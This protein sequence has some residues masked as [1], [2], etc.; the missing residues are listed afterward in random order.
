MWWPQPSSWGHVHLWML[1]RTILKG[2]KITPDIKRWPFAEPATRYDD[3]NNNQTS[4]TAQHPQTKTLY[5]VAIKRCIDSELSVRRMRLE[6]TV[7]GKLNPKLMVMIW[8]YALK[9]VDPC[10]LYW[11]LPQVTE[12]SI[13]WRGEKV[14]WWGYQLNSMRLLCLLHISKYYASMLHFKLKHKKGSQFYL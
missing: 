13:I 3:W 4:A 5:I 11:S 7:R 9:T 10:V 12:L 8:K 1:R 2:F 6:R 14:R